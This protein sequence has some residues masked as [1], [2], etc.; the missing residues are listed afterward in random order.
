[1]E[2]VKEQVSGKIALWDYERRLK[3][4]L[5]IEEYLAGSLP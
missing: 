4:K 5:S 1:M 3:G 2:F